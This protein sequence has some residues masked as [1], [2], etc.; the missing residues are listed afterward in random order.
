VGI[1]ATLEPKE[2]SV[3]VPEYRAGKVQMIIA[4]WTPDYLDPHP[5]ADAFYKKGGPATKRVFYDNPKMNDL[6]ANGVRE[7][8][9]KKR[10]EIYREIV[11]LA[12]EDVPWVPMIQAK[13]SYA[14]NPALK[15][16]VYHP[17]WFV[18]LAN[19]SR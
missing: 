9:P 5:W 2:F 16:F 17:V 10:A 15:G 14:L 7:T 8:D 3:V 6:I 18:T 19:V 12:N 1:K 4:E 13:V 11:K